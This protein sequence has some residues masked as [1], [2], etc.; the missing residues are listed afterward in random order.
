MKFRRSSARLAV[1]TLCAIASPSALAADTGPYIGGNVGLSKSHFDELRISGTIA[2]GSGITG[3]NDDDRDIGWK[4]YGGYQFH[5]NLAAE[6]GYFDLGKFGFAATT[7]PAGTLNGRMKVRGANLDLVG[8][9]PLTDRFSAFARAGVIHAQTKSSFDGTGA[10][11]PTPSQGKETKT[12]YKFGL[13]LEYALTQA[14]A[15]RAE[16]ERYRVPDTVGRK[17]NV[18]LYSLGLVYRWGKAAPAPAYVPT[19]VTAPPPRPEVVAPPPPPPPRPQAK[20]EVVAPPP[21]PPPQEVT[22]P[23]ARKSAPARQD[24]Y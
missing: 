14:L 10:V 3:I 21:P 24:R 1:A 19:A 16:A 13:G 6:L 8:T 5:P 22:P 20:P 11:V 23:P 9:L 2:P 17:A 12:G 4:A 18:D 15:F 7:S